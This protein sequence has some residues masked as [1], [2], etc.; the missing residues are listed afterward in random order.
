MTTEIERL[1]MI[2]E[3]A[4]SRYMDRGYEHGHDLEDWLEA[5]AEIDA[6]MV[7]PGI[8]FGMQQGGTRGP[9][10][11]EAMKRLVRRHPRKEIPLVEGIE[12]GE[13]PPRE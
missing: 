5:E 2:R 7:E 12:S 3:A 1:E 6:A 10:G 13:A 4:Y 11:D 9:A 8:E